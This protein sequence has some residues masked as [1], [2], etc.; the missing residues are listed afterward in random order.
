MRTLVGRRSC[1]FF[2]SIDLDIGLYVYG[3][4]GV[5]AAVLWWVADAQVDLAEPNRRLVPHDL[6]M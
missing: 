1:Q 6:Q 5:E 2:V 4:I 3:R